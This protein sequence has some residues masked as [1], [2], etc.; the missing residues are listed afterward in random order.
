MKKEKRNTKITFAWPGLP[1]YAARCIKAVIDRH[2]GEVSVI[3]TPPGVPLSGVEDSLGREV[4]W[5]DDATTSLSWSSLGLDLPDVF[6]AGGY[7]TPVFNQLAR[8]VRQS[9]R[10]VILMSDNTPPAS[11]VKQILTPFWN[12][13]RHRT[14]CDG[15][16]VPGSSARHH[17][18]QT[19]YKDDVIW[20]GLYGAD[21][22]L[23]GGGHPLRHRP[24]SMIFAGQF[25]DR[26]NILGLAEGFRRFAGNHPEWR[27][28]LCG[29]G[30]LKAKIQDDGQV[31]LMP[32][33]PPARLAELMRN[34]RC[35][36]LPSLREHW[37]VVVHEAAASGCALILSDQVG[38]ADDLASNSNALIHPAGDTDAL[39][40]AFE[41]ISRWQDEDWDQA[42]QVSRRLAENFGPQ[43]FAKSVAAIINHCTSKRSI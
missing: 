37:G 33:V 38:A 29:A 10:Q 43:H 30:P 7:A 36:V 5:I 12:R 15:V 28:L 26:K 35:L 16:F 1:D 42:E 2:P 25:I 27:L 8:E 3:A 18:R 31:A 20:D 14:A 34:S 21:P 32:F 11:V 23:F 24:R 17:A 9:D 4:H 19:G 39:E 41:R 22:V 6:F 13:I 40:Q